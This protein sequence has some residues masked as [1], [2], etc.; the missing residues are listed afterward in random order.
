MALVAN[1][2]KSISLI[3]L[4]ADN[5]AK[6]FRRTSAARQLSSMVALALLCMV[7]TGT[8]KA[9][10]Q[11]S[12]QPHVLKVAEKLPGSSRTR[13]APPKASSL[14]GHNA[15]PLLPHR[16]PFRRNI[17]ARSRTRRFSA[18]FKTGD[19]LIASTLSLEVTRIE[20]SFRREKLPATRSAP[21]LEP[22]GR[23]PEIFA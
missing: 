20:L 10:G 5:S 13:P 6:R 14:F 16:F 23:G 7:K 15:T 11:L 8:Q 4:A 3:N 21:K 17:W 12:L 22:N 9:S 2:A 18:P 19:E 1:P